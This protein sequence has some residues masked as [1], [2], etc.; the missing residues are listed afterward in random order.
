MPMA[1]MFDK[2][3]YVETLK[4]GG[5]EERQARA[6]AEALA[7]AFEEWGSGTL[8]TRGDLFTLRGDMNDLR[9]ELKADIANL[10]SDMTELR[11]ELKGDIANLRSEMAGLRTEL[12]GDNADLR[13]DI[14]LMKWMFATLLLGVGSLVSKTYF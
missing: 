13:S 5:V 9:S 4:S 14:K 11:S 12:K 10:R 7:A 1:L 6:G 2:L 8:A 3:R